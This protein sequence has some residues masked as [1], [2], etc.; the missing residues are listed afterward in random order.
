MWKIFFLPHTSK[1]LGHLFRIHPVVRKFY[2]REW[3]STSGIWDKGFFLCSSSASTRKR[4]NNVSKLG[5]S[6]NLKGIICINAKMPWRL[7]ENLGKSRVVKIDPGETSY[8][9]S[10]SSESHSRDF[11]VSRTLSAK[12]TSRSPL[13]KVLMIGELSFSIICYMIKEM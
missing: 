11:K 7:S 1:F 10:T 9:F 4:H 2:F 5:K 8:F 13:R 3:S 6:M 12:L